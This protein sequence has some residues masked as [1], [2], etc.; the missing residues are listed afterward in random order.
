MGFEARLQKQESSALTNPNAN[1][2]LWRNGTKIAL[3]RAS[4]NVRVTA[5]EEQA[6]A[7]ERALTGGEAGARIVACLPL[8]VIRILSQRNGIKGRDAST[9]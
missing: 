7:E 8:R 4:W 9:R 1:P 3:K 5:R 2:A 6:R